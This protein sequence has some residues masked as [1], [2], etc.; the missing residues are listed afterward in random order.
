MPKKGRQQVADYF[1]KKIIVY[2]SLWILF[3]D[4][5]Y[6]NNRMHN[7]VILLFV[8]KR[9]KMP[10]TLCAYLCIQVTKQNQTQ[11]HYHN[12]KIDLSFVKWE[13]FVHAKKRN[14][15]KNNLISCP[16]SPPLL[17]VPQKKTSYFSRSI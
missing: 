13:L 15:Q 2:L 7:L 17:H 6:E 1:G 5:G 4:D 14:F 8:L 3:M 12:N 16:P 9:K 11:S 10:P